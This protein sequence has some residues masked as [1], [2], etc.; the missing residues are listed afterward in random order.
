MGAAE[1]ATGAQAYA[2]TV[3]NADTEYSLALPAGTRAIRVQARGA[4]VTRVAFESGKV[5][6]PTDPYHTIK[7]G[8]KLEKSQLFT[9]A[10]LYVACPSGSQVIEVLAF[11]SA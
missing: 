5:A 6:T 4:V 7:S 8:D 3:T 2:I 11:V 1:Y 9:G 10:T